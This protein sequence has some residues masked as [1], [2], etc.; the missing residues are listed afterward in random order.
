MK[1]LIINS[2][3]YIVKNED[4]DKVMEAEG[5]CFSSA[6]AD[7][8]ED[9]RQVLIGIVETHTPQEDYSTFIPEEPINLPF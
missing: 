5:M 6:N 7:N 2:N 1:K 8:L 9:L 3:L 4:F